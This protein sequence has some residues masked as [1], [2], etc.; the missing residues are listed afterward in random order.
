MEWVFLARN[1][2]LRSDLRYQEI[3]IFLIFSFF[4]WN[5]VLSCTRSGSLEGS[6][7]AKPALVLNLAA[8][9]L[10]EGLGSEHVFLPN[11]SSLG[12]MIGGEDRE[13]EL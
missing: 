12:D 6:G 2:A 3:V 13:K 11:C 10:F 5:L 1:G 4:F 9:E 7:I 8:S